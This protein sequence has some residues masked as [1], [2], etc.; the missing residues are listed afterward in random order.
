HE[1]IEEPWAAGFQTDDWIGHPPVRV[2][3]FLVLHVRERNDQGREPFDNGWILH[4]R[5][6]RDVRHLQRVDSGNAHHAAQHCFQ[7]RYVGLKVGGLLIE[8]HVLGS[9]HNFGGAFPRIHA[10]AFHD[11]LE[12]KGTAD[13][14]CWPAE[15]AAP[16][17]TASDFDDAERR[18][19][20]HDRDLFNRRLHALGNLDDALEGRITGHHAPEEIAENFFNLAV[21]QVIDIEF[22]QTLSALQ[23][24]GPG[25]ADDNLRPV[26]RDHGMLN[27]LQK[28]R[29]VQ[30][31]EVLAGNLGIDVGGIRN[32]ERIVSVNR[33]DF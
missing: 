22:V 18:T 32:A 2:C 15:L 13:F 8:E 6:H 21:N 17:T 24:P 11:V 1:D 25:A 30:W 19:M 12:R 4:Y 33:E 28:F 23:L 5:R 7:R 26:F 20:L 31:N 14:G 16:A 27:D 9:Q 29:G 3:R 10:D